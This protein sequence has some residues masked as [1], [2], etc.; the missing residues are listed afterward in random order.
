MSTNS[1]ITI[2]HG[3]NDYES[4][5]CHWDGYVGWNGQLLFT[6][7]NT[8]EKAQELINH[9]DMSAL[10]MNIGEKIDGLA[11]DNRRITNFQCEF[12]ER[13]RGEAKEIRH[14][15]SLAD[16]PEQEFNY[17]F[18]EQEGVWYV[19][20]ENMENKQLLKDALIDGY[21]KSGYDKDYLFSPDSSFSVSATDTELPKKISIKDIATPEQLQRL[22]EVREEI[23]GEPKRVL[24]LTDFECADDLSQY[25]DS[26]FFTDDEVPAIANFKDENNNNV[27]VRIKVEG[28]VCV[29]YKG[30]AYYD[31]DDFPDDLKKLIAEGKGY[32]NGEEVQIDDSNWFEIS[33]YITNPSGDEIAYDGD[34]LEIDLSEMTADKLKEYLADYAESAYVFNIEAIKESDRAMP[35]KKPQKSDVERGE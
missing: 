9:G 23:T 35:T 27:F 3:E 7:Y 1:T 17:L 14:L 13:D 6:F 25:T 32:I 28:E 2:K 10:G 11:F 26:L 8:A 24:V 18:D 33:F 19:Y 15:K 20:D 22:D 5:Y 34:T 29:T 21:R 31:P 16:V 4:V 12:Y 30:E